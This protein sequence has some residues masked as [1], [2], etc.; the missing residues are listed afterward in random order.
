MAITKQC[1]V[2][3]RFVARSY[4]KIFAI[5]TAFAICLLRQKLFNRN[6]VM[7]NIKKYT[8]DSTGFSLIELMTVI[9]IIG[10]M[11]AIAAPSLLRS[12][13]EKQLKNAARNLY[14]DMQKARLLAV[15][16]NRKI[17]IRFDDTGN[18][19]YF[20]YKDTDDSTKATFRRDLSE[21]GDVSFGFGEALKKFDKKWDGDDLPAKYVDDT[22]FSS[23]GTAKT[24]SIFM[25]NKNNDV[26]YAVS[27]INYGAV[28]IRRFNG[29]SW[30]EKN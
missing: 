1:C 14:A 2:K 9:A 17:Y 4:Q 27:V 30:D 3:K 5:G 25:H 20:V 24:Q 16:E 29:T 18:F 6:S 19:Y 21:Y 12:L 26:C 7:I 28:K 23:T 8:K 10:M 15:K 11:S 13:P 22:N